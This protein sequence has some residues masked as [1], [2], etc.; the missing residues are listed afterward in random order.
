[1]CLS[2][3][4]FRCVWCACSY[5]VV[6]MCIAQAV[7]VAILFT[8]VVE[9]CFALYNRCIVCVFL[10]GGGAGGP[11]QSVSSSA[12]NGSDTN[13]VLRMHSAALRNLVVFVHL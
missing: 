5:A 3:I 2:K 12:Y 9:L 8:S 6:L 1:M 7:S 4:L 10:G 13:P 11:A